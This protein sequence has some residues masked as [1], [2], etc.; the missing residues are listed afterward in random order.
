[1]NSIARVYA[2]LGD[3]GAA[4][5]IRNALFRTSP[6]WVIGSRSFVTHATGLYYLASGDL[7]NARSFLERHREGSRRLRTPVGKPKAG[8]HSEWSVRTR[9]R[10][11]LR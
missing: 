4:I 1:M 3:Y 10:L 8:L 11:K 7:I 5:P 6:P 9:V 2:D